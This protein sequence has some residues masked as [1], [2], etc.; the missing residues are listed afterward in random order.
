MNR[1]HALRAAACASTRMRG[2][3]SFRV[4]RTG[5]TWASL[6]WQW[7]YQR[8]GGLAACDGAAEGL[9][10]EAAQLLHEVAAL[11]ER[12]VREVQVAQD[13]VL[14]TAGSFL[15]IG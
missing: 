4:C 15:L 6:G 2:A 9:R 12:N 3:R 14:E 1:E 13:V 8:G 10:L 5:L 11:H 7:E